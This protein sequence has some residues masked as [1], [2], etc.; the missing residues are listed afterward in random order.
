MYSGIELTKGSFPSP[1]FLRGEGGKF[2]S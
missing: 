1:Y 2:W